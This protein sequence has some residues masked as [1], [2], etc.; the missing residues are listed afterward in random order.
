LKIRD[1]TEEEKQKLETQAIEI[2]EM[3]V[4]ERDLDNSLV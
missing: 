2:V 4:E 3:M 1:A